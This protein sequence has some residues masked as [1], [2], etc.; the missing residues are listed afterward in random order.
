[1]KRIDELYEFECRL[2]HKINRHF[3]KRILNLFF[4][5]GTHL[6]GATL[7]ISSLFLLLILLNGQYRMTVI[8]CMLSLTISHIPVHF[9]K[10]MYPRK[11]P[12]LALEH[13]Q[14]PSNPLKDYSFPS[15]H[16]TAILS[17]ITPFILMDSSL[18]FILLP[19]GFFVGLSRIYLGLHY[20][21]DVMAGGM[22]G[23]ICGW[24]SYYLIWTF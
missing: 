21:S 20:P 18:A 5:Y 6:G 16:T 1:M 2:V 24:I 13:V 9:V 15:G 23:I 14:Y 3:N 11:R 19:T 22:L 17:V 7:L 10:K 4:R 12:Y 8:S